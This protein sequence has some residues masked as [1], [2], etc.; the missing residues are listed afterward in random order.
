MFRRRREETSYRPPAS[1]AWWADRADGEP[2]FDPSYPA[3]PH[4]EGQYPEGQYAAAH[5]SAGRYSGGRYPAAGA[6]DQAPPLPSSDPFGGWPAFG[7]DG[8]DPTD[9]VI[10]QPDPT[11]GWSVPSALGFPYGQPAGPGGYGVGPGTRADPFQPSTGSPIPPTSSGPPGS[12]GPR[13]GSRP[14]RAGSP[15]TAGSTPSARVP[16]SSGFAGGP[17]AGFPAE[18]PDLAQ[19]PDPALAPTPPIATSAAFVPPPDVTEAAEPDEWLPLLTHEEQR[20]QAELAQLTPAGM[21]EEPGWR[22]PPAQLRR[23]GTGRPARNG[24]R[25]ATRLGKTPGPTTSTPPRQSPPDHESVPAPLFASDEPATGSWY[26]QPVSTNGTAWVPAKGIEDS[27]QPLGGP[28]TGPANW[29]DPVRPPDPM[30]A[31]AL[32]GAF[33]AD[34]L[35]WD[36]ANPMRRGEVLTQY[37]PSDVTGSVA[38]VALLGWSGKGR[39]RSEFALPGAVSLDEEGRLVVDVRVRVTPYRPVGQSAE[40]A[41]APG[42]ELEVAGVPSVAPA[43]TARGWKSLDSHWI[44]LAVPVVREHGRLVVDTWD[45]QPGDGS[46]RPDGELADAGE[47]HD[48]STAHSVQPHIQHNDRPNVDQ[49]SDASA[50]ASASP[51]SAS[52]DR[53]S[54]GPRPAGARADTEGSPTPAAA[55]PPTASRATG[56]T[57]PRRTTGAQTPGGRVKPNTTGARATRAARGSG[58]SRPSAGSSR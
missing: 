1:S 46:A 51:T 6:A 42:D 9:A 18:S 10:G 48:Q 20:V 57:T 22:P 13:A 37:L 11:A 58:K 21:G 25:R 3:G 2:P 4:P 38:A 8:G 33:A 34:Y 55:T 43:P 15:P 30:A 31:A 36:E 47:C 19:V 35:S 24:K 28:S 29:P 39:Q 26:E 23:P 14:T 50:S 44:R 40:P 54:A 56:G 45:E 27:V 16:G 12:S 17:L 41:S 7:A 52:A 5:Y 32:A 49:P 53:T